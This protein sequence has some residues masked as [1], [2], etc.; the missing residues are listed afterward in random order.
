MFV[1]SS[2]DSRRINWTTTGLNYVNMVQE[3]LSRAK[4]VFRAFAFLDLRIKFGRVAT[5][6]HLVL[7]VN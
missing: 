7:P 1:K 4:E 6:N 2:Q 3:R 5:L